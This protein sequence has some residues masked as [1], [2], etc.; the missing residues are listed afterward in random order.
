[1][2]SRTIVTSSARLHHYSLCVSRHGVS[3][4]D[5]ACGRTDDADPEIIGRIRIAIS[6][7]AVQPDPA[8][9]AGDSNTATGESRH[10]RSVS[11]RNVPLDERSERHSI[12]EDS[13]RTVCRSRD[14]LDANV[15]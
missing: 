11:H 1:M 10:G 12:H 4:D 2:F 3:V 13:G 7:C 14:V 15:P 9:M 8:V 6:V 5:I